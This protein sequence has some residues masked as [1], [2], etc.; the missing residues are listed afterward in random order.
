M[1]KSFPGEESELIL[2][3]KDTSGW[4]GEEERVAPG[5]RRQGHQGPEARSQ[6][7]HS[8]LGGRGVGGG[9]RV[10]HRPLCSTGCVEGGGEDKAQRQRQRNQGRRLRGTQATISRPQCPR[11]TSTLMPPLSASFRV[12]PNTGSRE[13]ATE[14]WEPAPETGSLP[15]HPRSKRGKQAHVTHGTYCAPGHHPT[16]R[17]I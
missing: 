12:L 10:A 2:E 6:W 15:R 9:H 4:D 16:N 5:Q 3:G 1:G 17:H 13:P 7:A 8:L 11:G 14:G